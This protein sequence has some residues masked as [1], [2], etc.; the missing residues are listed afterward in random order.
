MS[1]FNAYDFDR[2]R[3]TDLQKMESEFVKM[4]EVLVKAGADPC[5]SDYE[6]ISA[7]DLAKTKGQM[8]QVK[9]VQ[10]LEDLCKKKL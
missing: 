3:G 1:H 8:T 2:S 5:L 7:L 10:L 9:I 4:V 6:G